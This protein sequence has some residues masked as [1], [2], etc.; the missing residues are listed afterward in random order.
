MYTG[1]TRIPYTKK[2]NTVFR[3]RNV[4]VRPQFNFP[5]LAFFSSSTS[6]STFFQSALCRTVY[7]YYCSHYSTGIVKVALFSFTLSF[8]CHFI[9]PLTAIPLNCHHQIRGLGIII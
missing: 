4:H 2:L 5:T 6:K 1:S 7:Y 9:A 3:R 8:P